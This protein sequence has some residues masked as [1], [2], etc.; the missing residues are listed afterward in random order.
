MLVDA[1]EL[2]E[3]HSTVLG[4]CGIRR[5]TVESGDTVESGGTLWNQETHCGVTSHITESGDTLPSQKIHF[6]VRRKCSVTRSQLR[7][8]KSSQKS[9]LSKVTYIYRSL[10]EL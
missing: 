5:R 1:T 8:E 3:R 10:A 7:H 2:T 9:I 4:D 6:G